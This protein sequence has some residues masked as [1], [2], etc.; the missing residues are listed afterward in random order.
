MAFEVR[1]IKRLAAS[2]SERRTI[3]WENDKGE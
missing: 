2:A 1:K 3:F